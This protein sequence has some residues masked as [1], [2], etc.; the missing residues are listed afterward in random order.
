M[1]A[2]RNSQ[3]FQGTQHRSEI[4][5]SSQMGSLLGHVTDNQLGGHKENTF[6]E[7]VPLQPKQRFHE[8]GEHGSPSRESGCRGA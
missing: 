3:V 2:T 5:R 6:S 4:S 1:L 7:S 8:L